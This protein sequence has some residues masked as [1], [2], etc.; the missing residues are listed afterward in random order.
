MPKRIA[1][2]SSV[3]RRADTRIFQKYCVSL[4]DFGFETYL[5]VADGKGDSFSR[6]VHIC[7]V[8]APKNRLNRIISSPRR[9]FDKAMAINADLYQLHDPELIPVALKLRRHGKKVVF[10]SHEDVPR[11][12]LAKPYLNKPL[13]RAIAKAFSIYESIACKKLDGIISATPFIRD[14]FLQINPNTID[15]NNYP[16][17]GEL[18]NGTPWPQKR[19]EI[20]YVGG[21]TEHRGI[22]EL[23]EAM[24]LLQ[25]EARLNLC[26]NFRGPRAIED[27]ARAH[28]GWNKINEFGVVDRAQLKEILSRSTI[29]LVTL[30]PI[31]NYVDALPVKMFEYMCAGI[32]VIASDFPTWRNIVSSNQCGVLVDPLDP[33]KISEA[34]DYLLRN[35][36][37][38]MRMGQ[39]G[40]RAVMS[41]YNWGREERKL[42]DFYRNLLGCVEV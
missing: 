20:C 21:I 15:I 37:E 24:H 41:Q 28:P 12:I 29:G 6:G 14:K 32:P 5:L 36:D 31:I 4:A 3:H 9:I 40:R 10:D 26:G 39:N 1:H 16:I 13:L 8:G 7:D 30:H 35:P 18:M 2:L 33:K 22:L 27:Q 25:S 17:S 38:A 23:C 34:I 19:A 42:L 11:Q